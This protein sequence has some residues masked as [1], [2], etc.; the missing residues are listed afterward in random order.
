MSNDLSPSPSPSDQAPSDPTPPIENVWDSVGKCEIGPASNLSDI[1]LRA[2]E[3]TIQ[4]HS[5]SQTARILSINRRTIWHWKTH[6]QDYRQTLAEARTHV[7]DCAT[8]RCQ[9]IAFK[10]TAVLTEILDDPTIT[11]RMRAAQILLN[12]AARLK[13][14]L[15]APRSPDPS[16]NWPEPALDPDKDC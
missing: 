6:N 4:G 10:A 14:T 12:L 5:D 13:P 15:P 9:N 3:L 8:D 1:Q 2:I 11:N 7:H 16:D